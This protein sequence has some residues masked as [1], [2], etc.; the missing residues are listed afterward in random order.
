MGATQLDGAL[1]A[2]LALELLTSTSKNSWLN[3][4]AQGA[5]AAMEAWTPDEKPNLSWSHPWCS[6]PNS[7]IVRL[8]MGVQPLEL[9]WKRMQVI[10]QPSSIAYINATVPAPA[11][12]ISIELYQRPTA[13]SLRLGIPAN[14]AIPS[15]RVCLP[16]PH[17][18]A[19]GDA[20]A[21]VMD[22]T[23]IASNTQ[24]RLLCTVSDVR[25]GT[26]DISRPA[27]AVAYV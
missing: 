5:T 14:A 1:A 2:D 13:I 8:L 23:V 17:G 11:G 18:V 12:V 20:P 26:F 3:M 27:K 6:S 9:G 4:I 15:A 10:P 7:V 21:L 24:G 25:P 22:G 16:P 19:P